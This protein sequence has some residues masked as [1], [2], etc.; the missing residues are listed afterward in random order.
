MSWNN[1]LFLDH[2]FLAG[3]AEARSVREGLGDGLIEAGKHDEAVVVLT[4]DLM[5][6]TAVDKFAGTFPERFIDVGIAEQNL[7]SVASGLAALGKKPFITSYAVFSPGRNW[8]QIRTNVC[9][10]NQPV[11]IVGTH[12]G[13]NVGADGG[14]HQMLEDIALMRV[15]PNMTVLSPCDYWQAK[16]MTLVMAKINAP[17]YLRLPREKMPVI[18]SEESPFEIGRAQI[19]WRD[20]GAKTAIFATGSM[21]AVAL[22]AVAEKKMPGGAVVVNLHTIKPLDEKTILAVVE[23]VDRV[24]TIEEH[25][26][27]GGMGSAIAELLVEKMPKSM[28]II[29]VDDVFGQSGKME[30]LWSGYGLSVG[31]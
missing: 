5:E 24:I 27:A 28:Q 20:D 6:S 7:V 10:N 3:K 25:Q 23:N 13:L 2:K 17:F 12:S 19:M 31:I 26:K 22:Q 1:D 16:H 8:E 15:L 30:E 4:A 11:R 9:Y 18:T 14:T 21:V 29:G